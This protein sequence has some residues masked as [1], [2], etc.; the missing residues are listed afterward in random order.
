MTALDKC[1]ARVREQPPFV[2]SLR[3][4]P[5]YAEIPLSIREYLE[6]G[7]KTNL[8]Q[9]FDPLRTLTPTSN[10]P[11]PTNASPQPQISPSPNMFPRMNTG[12]PI[13]NPQ[14]FA[15]ANASGG[16]G[17]GGGVGRENPSQKVPSL[18]QN[19]NIRTLMS[20]PSYALVRVK[21]PSEQVND[22]V[23]FTFNNLSFANLSQKAEE[24]KEVLGTD[25]QL[26]KWV[27][28]YLVMKRASI[29]PNF[30]S[31]YAGFVNA[32]NVA[33][34]YDTVLSETHRN[35]K[36]LLLSDKQ[37]NNI[38]D[39]ALLK[40]LGHWLGII[41]IAKDKPILSTDLEIKSLCIE[42]FH[43][44]SQELLYII[45]FVAKILESCTRSKIFQQPNP[46]LMGIMS[47]LAEMHA[48]HE[49][50]LN[51]K[52]EIE[53]L[54]RQLQLQLTD[55]PIH[56]IL[57]NKEVFDKIEKQLSNSNRQSSSSLAYS[58]MP[59]AN[60]T[61]SAIYNDP[62]I[63]NYQQLP[64][65]QQSSLSTLPSL[66]TPQSMS[67]SSSTLPPVP[68]YKL[69][70]FKPSIFQSLSSMLEINPN[71]LLFQHHPRLK[72]Y[73]HPPIEQAINESL[74]TVQRS[75]KVATSA[76]ET[77][78][79]KDFLL[80]PDEQQLRTSARNMVAYLSSGLVLI[81]ARPALQDQIQSYIK[82]HLQTVLGISAPNSASGN[83]NGTDSTGLNNNSSNPTDQITNQT[84]EMIQQA[85]TEIAQSNIELCCC[86][87]QRITI[88]RAIQLIDQ[89]LAS[90]IEIRQR[91]RLEGRQLPTAANVAEFQSDRL[92]ES[93]RLR[94]GPLSS[95]QLAIYEDFVHFIP[96]FKPSDN[97]KREPVL[98]DESGPSV[99]D[100]LITEIEQI[101]QNQHNQAFANALQRLL[102]SVNIL[103]TN[104]HNQASVSAPQA[105]LNNV[106]NLILYNLLEHYTSQLQNQEGDNLERF[107]NVHMSVLKV[108][109]ELRLQMA[110]ITK[111][112]TKAWIDCPVELKFNVYAVNQ[113][114]RNRLIDIRQIDGYVAQL[115][116]TGNN[117]A[118]QFAVH[119]LRNCVIEQP[120]CVDTDIAAMLDSLHRISL[121]GKQP[122]EA[123]RDL[124]EIIRLNYTS[125]SN[126]NAT[127]ENNEN[128][129]TSSSTGKTD[130][131]AI[132]SLSVIS[133]GHKYL[134]STDEMETAAI[135]NK[136]KHILTDWVQLTMTQTNRISQ[137]QSF[138][139][140]FNQMNM[141]GLFRSDDTV[142]KFLRMTIQLC[143][144]SV[145]DIIRQ[146]P[147]P[148]TSS[149]SSATPSTSSQQAHYTRCHQ[150]IDSLC[151]FLS[152]LTTHTSDM[153]NYGARIHLINRILGILAAHCFADHEEQ[154]DQ[155]HPLSY[156]RII[157]NLFQESTAALQ[158]NSTPNADVSSN[159]E[160][161]TYYI[162][163]A[164]TNCLHLLRPQRVPGFAFAW[165][166]IVAHRTFMSRLLLSG[167]RFTRQTHQMYALL[168]VDALRLVTPFIRAGEHAQ[169]FQVYFKGILKTF[170]LLLH[171]FP[172]FLCEHYY[173]FCDALPL[174]AHQLR[175]IVLSAFPK[176]MRCP[177]PFLVNFKV[178]ML[179]DISIVPVIAYNFSQNIQPPK[180]KQNLDSYLRTRAPVTFLSELRSY[181]QQGADPGSHYNIRMLNALVL[182]VATQ[183]LSTLNNKTNGQPLMSSIT[184]SAHMDIFQ[185]L[186]V[187][188]DTEG[189]YIFLNAMANHLRYPNTHTHYFS[190][191][192]LY[193]F[194]E[195]NS[196]ALQEQIVR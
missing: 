59:T 42:A 100:R 69:S 46:W 120:C 89:R 194:A 79:R 55:I 20:D 51:L 143:V 6:F 148:P 117:A 171:D 187:D 175:N 146:A 78:V 13:T 4:L 128:N 61:S 179:N 37:M 105:A 180:F 168:L 185:N 176:H 173:Q 38:P 174:V 93:I 17:G 183:A 36:I 195:A 88:H 154:G 86:L 165:L 14:Q 84:R 158:T 23:A 137:Q 136:A 109:V 47:V 157:L 99:W 115:I 161:V 153:N 76:A 140:I 70:D 3:N 92:I 190:Y 62:A 191:T 16:G 122:A 133:N 26:W 182:Y 60:T 116:D 142:A 40:N 41:T 83:A 139:T 159:N 67:S 11:P 31:L 108:L 5:A 144:N 35:I 156:Q 112:L 127:N 32:I 149:S 66:S 45:P 196:E 91:C 130:K 96:G 147:P 50:K 141:Q 129:S 56:N 43:M 18:T 21:P 178:D 126:A 33:I 1:K 111:Q 123:V 131:L 48:T 65:L 169:S 167:G 82:T 22:K 189:R 135:A 49:F 102:E 177:D 90:D 73:I 94:Y 80:N 103:R 58:S 72:T 125:L 97:E 77:I 25:E 10:L 184:H 166:E 110:L 186:A 53:V 164:F 101:T 160:L 34:L 132:I 193:L 75:L 12:P 121:I 124:L 29:E 98:A 2:Q 8:Q 39:R 44:G 71:I 68:K 152:L 95:H 54:C 87:L 145:Y 28:Q 107:K 85:A 81:T 57:V 104:L 188:L 27:A 192:L 155:F 172:E 163:L 106:L 19:A 63:V 113:L 181:L 150:G 15:A 138:Q 7:T 30:H 118:L 24:L 74:Q 170:M 162:Y 9:T 64:S 151:R 119:F 134:T 52:F 114:V